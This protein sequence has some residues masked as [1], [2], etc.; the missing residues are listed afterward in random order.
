MRGRLG[1]I[2]ERDI[3][4][5]LN[6][7]KTAE[8]VSGLALEESIEAPDTAYLPKRKSTGTNPFMPSRKK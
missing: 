2:I 6:D 8:V 5:G 3:K 1:K 7:E 4:V